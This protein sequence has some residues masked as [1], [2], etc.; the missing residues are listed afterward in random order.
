M[1]TRIGAVVV[2]RDRPMELR[3]ATE[4]L[5]AQTTPLNGIIVVDNAGNIPASITLADLPA[6]IIRFPAN[7]GG[8]GGFRAGMERALA[9]GAD[10]VWLMDDDAIPDTGALSM[11]LGS[12]A[13]L[14]PDTGALCGRVTECGKLAL[15]HRR[16]FDDAIGVERPVPK[17][18]YSEPQVEIRTASFVGLLVSAVAAKSIGLPDADFFLSYDDT[19]Y[20]LRLRR[21]GWRTFLVPGSHIMHL[22]PANSRMRVNPFGHKHYYNVRNRIVVKRRFCRFPMIAALGGVI[23]GML[24]W[25]LSRK[26]FN[27]RSFGIF[28]RA[29]ADGWQER[30]GPFSD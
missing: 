14:P 23:L 15:R 24:I 9:C 16:Y 6:E 1:D 2:T 30:L 27:R 7:I 26:P 18:L 21:A 20:S 12:L 17:R 22:R 10:W 5:L 25:L 28:C 3:K 4:A 13:H 19:E 11:L 8:A 29:L